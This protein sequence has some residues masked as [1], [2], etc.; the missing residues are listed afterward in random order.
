MLYPH[1]THAFRFRPLISY[2]WALGAAKPPFIP[3]LHNIIM[4]KAFVF[5]N[6]D[7]GSE[8]LTVVQVKRILGISLAR[9]L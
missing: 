9:C 1:I 8:E 3:A 6:C 5:L 2:F 7:I 4:S